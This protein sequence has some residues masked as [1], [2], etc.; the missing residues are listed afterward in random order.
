[1]DWHASLE[2]HMM[3]FNKSKFYTDVCAHIS[4]SWS[5]MPGL[6]YVPKGVQKCSKNILCIGK[7]KTTQLPINI[8]VDK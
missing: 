7:K 3:I 4:K 8:K 1:M 6:I 5:Y 2:N